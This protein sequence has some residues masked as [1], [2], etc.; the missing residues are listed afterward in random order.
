MLGGLLDSPTTAQTALLEKLTDE[1]VQVLQTIC[2]SQAAISVIWSP[3]GTGKSWVLAALLG[4]FGK[5]LSSS[6]LSLSFLV[7]GRNA[8]RASLRAALGHFFS[9]GECFILESRANGVTLGESEEDRDLSMFL[10]ASAGP[11][12]Q[13]ARD[14]ILAQLKTLDETLEALQIR[15]LG[16]QV[17]SC[18]Q[19]PSPKSFQSLSV[20]RGR[21]FLRLDGGSPGRCVHS[22]SVTELFS[23]STALGAASIPRRGVCRRS[24]TALGC[25]ADVDIRPLPVRASRGR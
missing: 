20:A 14:A 16:R 4:L 17:G 5:A 21:L 3:P 11:G 1:Q 15:G 22:R 7:T 18:S 25:G 24:R 2:A 19:L 13:M 6:D 9:P 10:G 23:V 12:V 8:R